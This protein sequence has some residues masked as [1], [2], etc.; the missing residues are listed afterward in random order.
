M[1]NEE[2]ESLDRTTQTQNVYGHYNHCLEC[3]IELRIPKKLSVHQASYTQN[4]KDKM[5]RTCPKT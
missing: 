1:T 5:I 3:A 2:N 4:D